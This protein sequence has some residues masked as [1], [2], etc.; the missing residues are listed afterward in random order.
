MFNPAG[1]VVGQLDKVEKTSAVIQRLVEE[2]LE[3]V[4][5]LTRL[6]EAASA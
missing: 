1:Q 6:T 2:Y 5:R 4:D 3:A